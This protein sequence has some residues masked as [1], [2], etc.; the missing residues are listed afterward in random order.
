[1]KDETQRS[2]GRRAAAMALTVVL[3]SASGAAASSRPAADR[4]QAALGEAE[5]RFGVPRE[6]LLAVI[7]A[8][9]AGDPQ[10]IS[11]AGAQGLMQ[12]MPGTWR[13]LR[14][15]HGFGA[16]PFDVRDNILAGAAYLRALHDRYGAPGFLA[17]Y[18]AGPGRYEAFRDQARP[19]PAE[20]R[21]Y[22]AKLTIKLGLPALAGGAPTRR[23]PPPDWRRAPLF[24]AAP[25]S[26]AAALDTLFP[27]APAARG[28]TA[29]AGDAL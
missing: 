17:A 18:N 1:M 16:D 7:A 10:A 9:S 27:A 14:Q 22:V 20:T 21:L 6:W 3:L 29:P 15:S 8:E 23:A 12:I 24:P 5:A 19:L 25:G 28:D 11:P 13:D 26:D 4:I 2:R